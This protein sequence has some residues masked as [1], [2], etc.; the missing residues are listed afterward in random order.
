MDSRHGI[1]FSMTEASIRGKK[2]MIVED[3]PLL[4]NLL[5]DKMTILREKG[6]EVYPMVN[7]EE[8]LEKVTE[9]KPD[10]VLLDLVLPGMNGFE[11][12]EKLRQLPELE[13]T[14]VVVLSNLSGEEDKERARKLGVVAYFIKADFSLSEISGAVEDVR[15]GRARPPHEGEPP[16]IKK[17]ASGG[18]MVYL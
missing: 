6:V 15:V 10:L 8:G 9:A 14:P 16:S 12:L 4:H 17:T 7:A 11:F 13:K 3:D 1:L 5:A 18:Y 2:V